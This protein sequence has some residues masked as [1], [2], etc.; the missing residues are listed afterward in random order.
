MATNYLIEKTFNSH[1]NIQFSPIF[2]DGIYLCKNRLWYFDN[3]LLVSWREFVLFLCLDLA[4]TLEILPQVPPLP[5]DGLEDCLF[6]LPTVIGSGSNGELSCST[7]LQRILLSEN[8]QEKIMCT[9][10]DSETGST[11]LE[12]LLAFNGDSV[13]L[14]SFAEAAEIIAECQ[15]PRHTRKL[16]F[17]DNQDPAVYNL[18][19]I[20]QLLVMSFIFYSRIAEN[21][22]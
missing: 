22:F 5:L 2:Q 10:L 4:K 11:D 21:K 20:A 15:W 19:S 6:L 17:L 14:Q 13:G 12:K 8:N 9:Y 18:S 7:D 1:T 16:K 3:F